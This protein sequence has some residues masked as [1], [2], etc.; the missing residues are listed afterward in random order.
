VHDVLA[1]AAGDF[2]D[3]AAGREFTPEHFE[4]RRLVAPR[5]RGK[6]PAVG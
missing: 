5:S 3:Q 1:G 6:Q 4:D 2:Q